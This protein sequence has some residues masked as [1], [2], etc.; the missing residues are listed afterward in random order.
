MKVTFLIPP[1][2]DGTQN[3]E[4][5]S[6]CNYGLYFFPLLPVLSVATLLKDNVARV[7]ILDFPAHKKTKNDFRDFIGNDNSDIYVFYTVLL[8]QDTDRMARQIIRDIRKE[9]RFIFCGPQPT[10][11]PESFLDKDDTFVVRAEPEFSARNL[12]LALKSKSGLDS[13]KGI[14]YLD[15][16]RLMHNPAEPFIPDIDQLPIPDRALL[17]HGPYCNPKLRKVPHAAI[18]T[19]RGCFGRCWFCVPNSLDYARELEYKKCYGRKPPPRLHSAKRVIDEFSEIARLGFKSVTVID[20]EFLWDENRTL[21]ICDGIKGLKLEWGCLA[22][23]DRVTEKVGKAMADAG[24]VFIDL[25]LESVDEEVLMAIRK[26]MT[27]AD[28]ERALAIFRKNK[29]EVELNVLMG[30]TPKE[31]TETIKRTLRTVKRL[32]PDYVLFSIA[33]PFPGTD[34]YYAAKKEG[35]MV[36]G[37]YV[38]A[39]PSKNAIISYPH[40]SKQ[41]LER[42]VSYAYFSFYFNP[43]YILRQ[44]F[45]VKNFQDLANKVKT[46]LRFIKRN[47]F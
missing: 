47:F 28:T 12:I 11:A 26:D 43:R 1:V 32:N 17:D 18:I 44:L 7:S 24:C 14:S 30:A 13:V 20:E 22:R 4:R 15:G 37:D 45:S 21:E 3:V 42:L 19:S 8:C 35:W 36:Y 31:T 10:Y 6:G 5:C 41:E 29:V 27:L 25:G 16:S 23:P 33:N 38:P 39:D 40:L 2:L 34:F 9:A 46:A